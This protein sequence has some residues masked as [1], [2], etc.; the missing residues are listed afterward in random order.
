MADEASPLKIR[1]EALP[2]ARDDAMLSQ[3]GVRY[4]LSI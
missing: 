1:G 4:G 3:I 2:A